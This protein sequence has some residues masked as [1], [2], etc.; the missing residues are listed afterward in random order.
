MSLAQYAL[1]I[2]LLVFILASNVGTR[3]VTRRRLLQPLVLVAVAAAV[4]LRDVP[5]LG[6]DG[7]LVAVGLVAGVMLGVVAGLLVT[8]HERSG[9]LVMT[10]GTAYAL[11]WVVVIVG[12]VLFAY[13]ADHWFTGWIRRFSLENRITGADAWTAAFI[14][15]A[16]AMVV[17]RVSVTWVRV[18]RAR[19]SRRH[20]AVAVTA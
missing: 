2:G 19:R 1:N 3:E 16:L 8:V 17:A 6:N 11:L 12:R 14:V 15:M 10:A 7:R 20:S 9:S 5:T 13:G 18:A 4:F